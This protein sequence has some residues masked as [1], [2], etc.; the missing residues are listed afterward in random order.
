MSKWKRVK[1]RRNI[2]Y[3]SHKSRKLKNKPG[4]D[5]YWRGYYMISGKQTCFSFGWESDGFTALECE[6]LTQNFKSNAKRGLKPTTLKEKIALEKKEIEEAEKSETQKKMDNITFNDFWRN[7]YKSYQENKFCWKV[8]K[9]FFKK[10][11]NPN[12]GFMKLNNISLTDI[13]KIQFKMEKADKSPTTS[14]HVIS[15]IGRVFKRAIDIGIF[16]GKSPT[17][18]IK[19]KKFDNSRKRF[20]KKDE[21]DILLKTLKR[22]SQKVHDI[23]L[24]SLHTG[25][26]GKEIRNLNWSHINFDIGIISIVDSKNKSRYVYMSDDVFDMLKRNDVSGGIKNN[27]NKKSNIIFTS[28]NGGKIRQISFTYRRTVEELGFNDGIEDTRQKVVFHTLRHTFAS[29]QVQSGMDLFTLQKLMGH[30]SFK[31]VQRY[32]HLAPENLQKATAIFNK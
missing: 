19:F 5:R 30:K 18:K 25:M 13:E 32:A 6:T 31:M 17:R 3:K 1:G 26:R 9:S 8:E 4:F 27:D 7:Y 23:A 24:L 2:Q 22:K 14:K 11:I 10:W 20:L 29:W 28:R 21:A 12:I 15:N 16:K